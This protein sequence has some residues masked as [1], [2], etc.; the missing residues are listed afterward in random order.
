MAEMKLNIRPGQY[1]QYS[2]N[3]NVQMTTPFTVT[4]EGKGFYIVEG[5]LIAKKDFES[6]YPLEI[7]RRSKHP[8]LKNRNY[9]NLD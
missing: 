5:E 2:E 3:M 1:I 4:N 6:M 7:V 8:P 9:R